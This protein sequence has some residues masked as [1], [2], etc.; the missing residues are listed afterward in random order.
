MAGV[1][2]DTHLIESWCGEMRCG[3]SG[4]KRKPKTKGIDKKPPCDETCDFTTKIGFLVFCALVMALL[5]LALLVMSPECRSLHKF[6][7][8]KN[9][10]GS[11]AHP[12]SSESYLPTAE[13]NLF[14]AITAFMIALCVCKRV[15]AFVETPEGSHLYGLSSLKPVIALLDQIN[16]SFFCLTC[17]CQFTMAKQNTKEMLPVMVLSQVGQY[18]APLL[19]VPQRQASAPH[20]R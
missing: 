4:R 15:H 7:N 17:G 19:R 8:A 16:M 13:G 1:E 3:K 2:R 11:A 9:N 6:T 10:G 20:G 5:P 18:D 14:G 12:D